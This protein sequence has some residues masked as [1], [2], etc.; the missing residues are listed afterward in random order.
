[1]GRRSG[2]LSSTFLAGLACG[3]ITTGAVA[4][5][6]APSTRAVDGINGKVE[7]FG[8]S[9]AT[10]GLYGA[11][12]SLSAPLADKFGVQLDAGAGSFANRFIGALGGHLFWRD[13]RKGLIG[14]Y[15]D[16]TRWDQYGGVHVG[17]FGVEGE[18]YL[19]RWSLGGVAGVESG[20]NSGGT[21]TSVGAIPGP[22]TLTTTNSSLQNKTRF[23]D[24]VSVSYYLTDNWKASVGHRYMGG[25]NALALGT[26]YAMPAGRG[27]MASL[28]AEGRAGEGSKN[29]GAW[30]GLRV[31]FGNSDK[32]LMRRQREDDPAG[33][34]TADTLFSIANGLGPTS[35]SGQ[36]V[37][38]EVFQSGACVPSDRR[39]KRDIALLARL[40]NGIGLYRYRYLWSDVVYVGVMAQEVAEIV[41]DAVLIAADGYYRVN[42]ALLGLRLL[43]WDE[44]LAQG[45]PALAA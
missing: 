15:G 43:T 9:Y 7:G 13:P 22:G 24:R 8:G 26:E 25:K 10:K 18:A 21:T 14:L 16:Y 2:L 12:G 27:M 45:A 36:C 3:L 1:M 42:Y 11:A 5:E 29:Y 19:G 41:P 44:W 35:T 32:S 33:D 40:D 6:A 23:F 30:G 37:S 31:Y 28:F 39:L 4:G 38:G 20:N 34:F 17:H